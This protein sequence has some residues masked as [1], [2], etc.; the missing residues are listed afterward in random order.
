M[1]AVDLFSGCGGMSLGFK[2]AGANVRLAIDFDRRHVETYN[3]NFSDNAC[4]QADLSQGKEH[5]SNLFYELNNVDLVFGGPPC[6]GFSV[7]GKQKVDDVRNDL[8]FSYL[9]S[10]EIL[11]PQVFVLENVAGLLQKNFSGIISEFRKECKRIGY[12]I[13]DNLFLLNAKDFNVPQNR[14][15][16]FIIGVKTAKKSKLARMVPSK[17]FETEELKNPTV[18]DAISDF[19][20]FEDSFNESE[21][22]LSSE[23]VTATPY[24]KMINSFEVDQKLFQSD[25]DSN[26]IDGF[27][28]SAHSKLV[29]DRFLDTNN[30]EREP[31]SRF[32]KLKWD[33]I[34]PTLRAGT[35][36]AN[37]QF[38]ASRPIHPDYPRCITVREAARL[39]SYPDKFRFYQTKWYGNMQIGNSVPPLMAQAVANSVFETL[40]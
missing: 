14:K 17:I 32:Y 31:I 30:G 40:F 19:A 20:E 11:Q 33:G 36:R 4:I 35:T 13:S 15:R 1:N 23:L 39:H 29:Q 16:V 18:F 21:N 26:L 8:I 24:S 25:V 7:G 28:I 2:R 6:Q 3:K 22:F 27:L 5:L 9:A 38:M 34:A 12:S 10:I 37:G